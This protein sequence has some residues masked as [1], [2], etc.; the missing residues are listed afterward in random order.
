MPR[1][2]TFLTVP[3]GGYLHRAVT[4]EDEELTHVGPGTPGG[5]YLRRFWQPVAMSSELK[6]LPVKVRVLGKDLVLFR[7]SAG[8]VGLLELHCSHRGTSL[9]F[10]IVSPRGIRCCYHSWL[11]DVDGRILETPGEPPTS[12][13]KDRLYHG[14][15]PAKEYKGLVFAYLGPP[16]RKPEF[17]I[18]DVY[19]QPDNC[20]VPY[21][22][23]YPCNWIQISENTMDPI[24]TV[25]LHT[26]IS[27]AHFANA[28][29]ELPVLEWRET[30][31]GMIYMTTRR[32]GEHVWVRSNDIVLPNMSQAGAIW[33]DA[34]REKIF[35]RAGLTRWTTPID[36]THTLIIGWRHFNETVDPDKRGRQEECGKEK[37][38]FFGQTGE[39]PYEERQRV[40]EDFDAQVSQRPIAI[41]ALEHLG[42]T[43]RGITIYRKL[44]RR[45]IR[46][47]QRGGDVE[48]PTNKAGAVIPTYTH[49]TVLRLPPRPSADMEYLREVGRTVT[50]IVVDGDHHAGDDRRASIEQLIRQR[51]LAGA[52]GG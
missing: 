9:E 28:W 51:V 3:Y 25:F 27:F 22:L 48:V 36:D 19:E 47:V 35:T 4:K 44:L 34:R 42:A 32:A 15:Y 50:E 46:R 41:H 38:D 1:K 12:T 31:L 40:P 52:T 8:R 37:V 26:K 10:G 21:S 18:Y 17:P 45:E 14:A 29:G 16:D 39:R 7:D 23:T 2:E 30:P 49:D 43:D 6:D 33:E 24:H 11:Y 5:E 13:L 20:M